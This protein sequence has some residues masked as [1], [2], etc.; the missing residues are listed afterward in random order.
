MSVS[1]CLLAYPNAD[2]EV[3]TVKMSAE[4]TSGAKKPYFELTSIEELVYYGLSEATAE[5]ILPTGYKIEE[6]FQPYEIFQNK[7]AAAYET[8]GFFGT[9]KCRFIIE[10]NTLN[11][12]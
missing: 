7:L 2:L 10:G 12:M 9:C 5:E 6:D 3:A 4:S 11:V 8:C 1:E